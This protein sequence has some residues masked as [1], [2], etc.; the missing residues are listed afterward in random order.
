MVDGV[1]V[2]RSI[3]A[4]Y[5]ALRGGQATTRLGGSSWRETFLTS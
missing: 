5:W 3:E 4:G 1:E 2:E